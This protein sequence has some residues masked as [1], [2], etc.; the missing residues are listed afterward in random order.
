MSKDIYELITARFIER[1]A[2]P[3]SASIQI[4]TMLSVRPHKST[5][6]R[7]LIHPIL[8]AQIDWRWQKL[9]ITTYPTGRMNAA[10]GRQRQSHTFTKAN[11]NR[12]MPPC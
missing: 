5:I 3:D 8:D 12:H 10:Y 9:N 7:N 4:R 1:L 11:K 6:A 2:A